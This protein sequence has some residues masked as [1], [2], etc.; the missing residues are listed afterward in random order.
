M[1]VILQ[2]SFV[3]SICTVKGGTHVKLIV[4]QICKCA[5]SCAA[6]LPQAAGVATFARFLVPFALCSQVFQTDSLDVFA[7]FHTFGVVRCSHM[8]WTHT[9]AALVIEPLGCFFSVGDRSRNC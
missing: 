3:N 1:W 2:V 7:Y 4:D 6:A 5:L 8:H 9:V